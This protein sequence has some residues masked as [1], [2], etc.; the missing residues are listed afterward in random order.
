MQ[1]HMSLYDQSD[2]ADRRVSFLASGII[3]HK[4]GKAVG[5]AGR[6]ERRIRRNRRWNGSMSRKHR[7]EEKVHTSRKVLT[8]TGASASQELSRLGVP[9]KD[10]ETLPFTES[11]R[12]GVI[13]LDFF[14]L[15]AAV[16]STTARKTTREVRNGAERN[17]GTTGEERWEKCAATRGRLIPLEGCPAVDDFFLLGGDGSSDDGGT[18]VAIE[19]LRGRGRKG[20]NGRFVLPSGGAAALLGRSRTA[21]GW[22]LSDW[23][24]PDP[25]ELFS[26]PSPLLTHTLCPS[27][28]R[29][30]RRG[31]APA[32]PRRRV[33]TRFLCHPSRGRTIALSTLPCCWLP[34][35]P[36]ANLDQVVAPPA[37]AA[38]AVIPLAPTRDFRTSRFFVVGGFDRPRSAVL[39]LPA[40][41]SL[42]GGAR[43]TRAEH[44]VC[45]LSLMRGGEPE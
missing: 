44:R 19:Q 35:P 13:L 17:P 21:R 33:N 34:W 45:V 1:E 41:R 10:P 6:K 43:R 24:W 27:V 22:I 31:N 7:E 25:R 11:R 29:L 39:R 14:T 16:L 28:R 38:I 4:V 23:S 2:L 32:W 36:R 40:R 8:P 3:L 42:R 26:V 30:V 20:R 18:S 9:E 37:T 12:W 5:R 15:H